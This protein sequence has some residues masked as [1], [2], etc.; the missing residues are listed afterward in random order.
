MEPLVSIIC[1]SYN[2]EAYIEEALK[3]VFAQEYERIEVIVLDD[4][5]TDDSQQ[6]ISNAIGDKGVKFIPHAKNIGYTKTFNEGL[7]HAKGE[8]IIDF[9]LD[10]VMLPGFVKTGIERFKNEP[11]TTGVVYSNADYIDASS[12]VSGNHKET[13]LARGMVTEMAEGDIFQ[14]VIR[15][16][17]ICTP[18]MIVRKEVFDRLE[19]YD[20]GLAYEDFDFWIRSSRYWHYAYIDEVHMRKRKLETSMS[21]NRYRHYQNKQLASVLEVCK[22]AFHLCKTKAELTALKARLNYEY[23]QSLRNEANDLALSYEEFIALVGGKTDVVS[24]LVK[25]LKRDFTR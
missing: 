8:F 18:T 12:K 15:R 6:Q 7:S 2:H 21:A 11:L 17:F 4:G 10:D 13:L 20:E 25:Y 24:K 14:Q 19:G 9:A 5:S 1:I 22:K 23:R 3:S 16:Y